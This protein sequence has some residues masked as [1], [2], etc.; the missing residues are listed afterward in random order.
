MYVMCTL[1]M[2]H[3]STHDRNLYTFAQSTQVFVHMQLFCHV[4]F[5][6]LYMCM[7]QILSEK[8][9]K[10]DTYYQIDLMCVYVRALYDFIPLFFS[11]R[12]IN[13]EA[14]NCW[15]YCGVWGWIHFTRRNTPSDLFSRCTKFLKIFTY[16]ELSLIDPNKE[17]NL[18]KAPTAS[19]RREFFYLIGS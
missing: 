13:L 6:F 1:P 14:E 8:Q 9:W 12:E 11:M 2:Y 16:V 15:A 3:L 18:H 4:W 17:I 10:R 5:F 19:A 7:C